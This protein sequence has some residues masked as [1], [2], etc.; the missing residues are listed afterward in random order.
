MKKSAYREPISKATFA[1]TR[2]Y[3]YELDVGLNV[4]QYVGQSVGRQVDDEI[5]NGAKRIVIDLT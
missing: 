2:T 5:A 3:T 4:G 1:V